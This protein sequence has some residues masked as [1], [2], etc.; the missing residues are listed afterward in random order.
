MKSTHVAHGLF[1]LLLFAGLSSS[2]CGGT[3][4]TQPGGG[5]PMDG[6]DS[7]HDDDDNGDGDNGDPS[8]GDGDEPGDGDAGDGDTPGDGD[9]GDGDGD[10]GDGD[11]DMGDGDMGDGDGDMGDGDGDNPP[12]D[13][14]GPHT[15]LPALKEACSPEIVFTNDEPEGRGKIFAQVIPDAETFMQDVTCTVCSIL[16]RSPDE[17][18]EDRRHETVNLHLMVNENLADTGGNTIRFDLNY[19]DGFKDDPEGALLEFHGVLVHESTHLYQNYGNGGL[20]EG[21]AD[22]VRIRTGLYEPGRRQAGGNWT[23]PYTTSGFFFSWL[24]GPSVYHADG[25]DPHNVDIGYLINKTIGQNGSGGSD[26]QFGVP[27][28]LKE[29]FGEDVDTLWN[30][31]QQIFK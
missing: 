3:T 20:G 12:D 1:A 2:A 31:Y 14:F 19:I 15:C 22:F 25:R 13:G 10:T 6:D 30:E 16:F 5:D 17:I 23:D 21:M 26:G 7:G 29:Q 27:Q 18:P 11:G 8:S 24:A 28:L 4:T 9:T